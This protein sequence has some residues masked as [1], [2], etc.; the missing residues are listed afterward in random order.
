[1]A[2]GMQ[3]ALW[4]IVGVEVALGCVLRSADRADKIRCGRDILLLHCI[5]NHAACLI[6][7]TS[8]AFFRLYTDMHGCI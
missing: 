5:Q 2:G 4:F 8:L 6:S 3:S 7:F 1:M